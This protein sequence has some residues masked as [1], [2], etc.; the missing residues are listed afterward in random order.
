[1]PNNETIELFGRTIAYDELI[2]QPE[3]WASV[4]EAI[5]QAQ[6]GRLVECYVHGRGDDSP[7]DDI[8]DALF[9]D[10]GSGILIP[11]LYRYA[12]VPLEGYA[13]AAQNAQGMLNGLR[14]QDEAAAQR[15]PE[16]NYR[17]SVRHCCA[18]CWRRGL[19]T[20]PL[21]GSAHS[22]FIC[23]KFECGEGEDDEAH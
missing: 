16:A 11:K 15:A 9:T 18:T 14:A 20:C 2:R 10:Y 22:E 8:G 1:M 12:I 3:L 4:A 23:D 6:Q 21:C 19:E 13:A 5:Q 7:F 17:K